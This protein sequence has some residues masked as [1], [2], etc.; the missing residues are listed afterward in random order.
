MKKIAGILC[1]CLLLSMVLTGC[2]Q[3]PDLQVF[4]NWLNDN[5]FSPGMNQKS[6]LYKIAKYQY[7]G[8]SLTPD[9]Q[10]H[11]RTGEGKWVGSSFWGL[12]NNNT[13]KDGTNHNYFHFYLQ[14]NLDNL[15]YPGDVRIGDTKDECLKKLDLL[16]KKSN[17]SD[18]KIGNKTCELSIN[19]SLLVYKESYDWI[20][21]DNKTAKIT[22][23]IMLKFSNGLLDEV[24]ITISEKYAS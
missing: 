11:E 24:G 23:T 10:F 20:R 7:L 4:D 2:K 12:N 9:S 8:K 13:S 19:G 18:I 5:E 21:T 6:M 1:L 17:V 15:R 22:R 3:A 16:D 14:K